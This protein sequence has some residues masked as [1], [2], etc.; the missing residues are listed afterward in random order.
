MNTS[1]NVFANNG[2]VFA[3]AVVTAPE[4][5]T[6]DKEN[7]DM[8]KSVEV[9]AQVETPAAVEP[10]KETQPVEVKPAEVKELAVTPAAPVPAP[11][12]EAKPAEGTPKVEEPKPE[13]S[14]DEFTKIA[15]E[16][17]AEV[18]VDTVRKGGNYTTALRLAYD[19][20]QTEVKQ[21]REQIAT[22]GATGTPVPVTAAKEPKKLFNTGK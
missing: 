9:A 5:T 16:F 15:D 13:L 18:A 10:T 19:R 22:K 21:L 11:A 6:K 8:S 14:R 7:A 12:V 3:A 2:K 20:L 1:T 17:G 4:A